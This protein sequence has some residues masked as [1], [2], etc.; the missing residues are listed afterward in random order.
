MS[1][2]SSSPI[3]DASG[4]SV[5]K[6]CTPP[7]RIQRANPNVFES[8][9]MTTAESNPSYIGE[10]G[11]SAGDGEGVIEKGKK[12]LVTPARMPPSS[13]VS[14][15]TTASMSLPCAASM[16][17]SDVLSPLSQQQELSETQ[18]VSTQEDDGRRKSKGEKDQ[19]RTNIR[20]FRR[21]YRYICSQYFPGLPLPFSLE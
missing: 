15:K 2:P 4:S 6:T 8:S 3:S 13:D 18:D 7:P 19:V 9:A 10:T 17:P 16:A 20:I 1:Q 12:G 5:R 11:F 21:V 14:G